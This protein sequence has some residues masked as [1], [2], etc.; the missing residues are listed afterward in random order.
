MTRAA[1]EWP[2]GRARQRDFHKLWAALSVSLVGSEITALALP[3]MAALTLGASPLEMGMLA[4]AGQL[5]FFLC[6]LPAGVWVDRVPRRPVLIATDLGSALLLLSIP[7]A[8][9]FGGPTFAQLCV[10]AFGV[11]TLTVVSEVAHYAYVPTLVGRR[12]LTE[13]NG[14]LQVSHSASEAAGPGLG[15][16]LV[17]LI[18]A[19]IAVLADAA[20]FVAS[21]GLLATIRRPEPPVRKDEQQVPLR[22]S[23]AQG[24]RLL[25]GHPLLRPII[26]GG[27]IANLF[28]SGLL[29]IY[30][31]YATRELGLNAGTIGLIFAVGGGAAIPGGLLADRVGKRIGVGRAIVGG[32]TLAAVGA[33]LV[34]LAA[35][36]G[37]LVV[38]L[39]AF[40]NAFGAFT[41]TIANVQ[42]WSLRQTVTPDHLA[43]R[44]TA[45]HRFIVYGAGAIG[46]LLGGVV[47]SAMGPRPAL[48]LCAAGMFFG[49]VIAFASPLR[50]LRDQPVDDAGSSP[51]D[52]LVAAGS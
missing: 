27:S 16:L 32:W 30:V 11:G 44:V 21:A 38:I 13:Y 42:Q 3:L 25:L 43:G 18:S 33:L 51:V 2:E 5:P 45:G 1:R 46:A 20:S 49:P 50:R 17:Q 6:S 14:R 52:E 28:E 12:R 9:P 8:V 7:L 37:W 23:I 41:D 19:P 36:P 31:L 24:L 10:V 48:F 40:A 39:L 34:P 4:A 35:G 29:A 47:G 15:G 22:R 26:V